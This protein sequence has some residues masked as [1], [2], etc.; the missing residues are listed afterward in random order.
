MLKILFGID[1]NTIL[2]I[3]LLE[4]ADNKNNICSGNVI[5]YKIDGELKAKFASEDVCAY[6]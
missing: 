6:K 2:E 3:C 4:K 5:V 1:L